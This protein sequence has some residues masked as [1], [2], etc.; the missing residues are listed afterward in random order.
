MQ[1]FLESAKISV[2]QRPKIA[3][4]LLAI[5]SNSNNS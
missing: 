2:F 1:I 3:F 5:K 4:G